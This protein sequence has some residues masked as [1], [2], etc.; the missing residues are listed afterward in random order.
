MVMSPVE[1]TPENDCAGETHK[2]YDRKSSVEKIAG[3]E[4]QGAWHQD[5]LMGGKPPVVK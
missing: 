5:E 4:S 3:R 2:D 1:L